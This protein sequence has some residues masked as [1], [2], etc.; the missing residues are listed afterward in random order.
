MTIIITIQNK[1]LPPGKMTGAYA[2][3]LEMRKD[4]GYDRVRWEED[5][6]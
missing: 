2:K 4:L 3:Y 6:E 1:G 5:E